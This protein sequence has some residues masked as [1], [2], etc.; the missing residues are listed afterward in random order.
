MT[1]RNV[2]D[3]YELFIFFFSTYLGIFCD[4]FPFASP[5]QF[6]LP[7]DEDM[8]ILINFNLIVKMKDLWIFTK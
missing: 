7:C 1:C 5:F 6:I 3:F 8:F 2:L 4:C